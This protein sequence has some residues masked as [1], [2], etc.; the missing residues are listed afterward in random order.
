MH[1]LVGCPGVAWLVQEK[2][3]TLPVQ[4]VKEQSCVPKNACTLGMLP[5]VEVH[6]TVKGV[7]GQMDVGAVRVV[8]PTG[9]SWSPCGVSML[10]PA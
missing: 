3:A 10:G 7:A 8:M 5:T 9:Q 6:W 1:L 4:E 2:D